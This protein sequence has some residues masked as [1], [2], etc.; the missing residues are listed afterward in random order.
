MHMPLAQQSLDLAA[1]ALGLLGGLALFLYGMQKMSDALK[2]AAGA[3]L[4]RLLARLTT[5]RFSAALTGALVTAVIQSSSVTTVLVV[6]FISARLMTLTQSVGVIMGANVGTTITAQIV[7]FKITQSA[8]AMV[9]LG[10]AAWSFSRRDVF[11]QYGAMLMGLGLLFVGME[12]MSAAT[13][14]LRTHQPFIDLMARMENPALGILLGAVFTALV[15]SSSAT[16]GILIMLASQGFLSLEGGI[17][18]SIGANVG[19]CATAVLSAIGKPVEAVRA[20]LVHVL[21]N[22]IGALIWVGL[23]AQLAN[24]TRAISPDYS[25]QELVERIT[26]RQ[27]SMPATERQAID[28]DLI[29]KEKRAAE[30][31][32]QVANANTMFNVANTLLLIGFAGPI[33]GLAVRLA[34]ERPGREPAAVEPKYLDKV[35]LETPSLALE[36]VRLEL[37]HMGER[38]EAMIKAAPAAL[39]KGQERDVRQIAEMDEAVDRLHVA[40]LDYLRNIGRAQLSSAESRRFEDLLA[41]ANHLETM[42]DLIE[43]N[44][45]AQGERRLR[46]NLAFSEQTMASLESLYHKVADAARGAVQAVVEVDAERAQ[47]V[48]DRKAEIYGQVDSTMQRLGRRLLAD[49]PERV[50]RFAVEAD[51]VAQIRRLYHQARQIA[52]IVMRNEPEEELSAE[53]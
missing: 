16:T 28:D 26:A 51:M 14:P 24:A 11:R 9:A 49:E 5:N 39:A 22:L 27:Q 45:V 18:L 29:L 30:T 7:A 15:Q 32:R 41:V 4:Q 53:G 48:I 6:G 33:A 13:S 1:L 42:G 12:Q 47:S 52:K 10:F 17:A 19:T 37:G 3:G 31:P 46:K 35:Y 8:W 38:V 21:F 40:V 43:T 23:I 2:A 25:R 44:L 20:A 36:R 50:E 34:P